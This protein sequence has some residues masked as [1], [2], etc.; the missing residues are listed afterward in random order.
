MTPEELIARS[1]PRFMN[2][3]ERDLL[4][5]LKAVMAERDA[6]IAEAPR[7]A[8]IWADYLEATT[9]TG[10]TENGAI[11]LYDIES[12]DEAARQLYDHARDAEAQA[13]ALRARVAE[14]EVALQI[15]ADDRGKCRTCGVLAVGEGMGVTACDCVRPTWQENDPQEVARAAL[16]AK[17]KGA[18]DGQP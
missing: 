14:L 15:I 13:A 11:D 8:E 5:A 17:A 12:M 16:R 7:A 6:L 1:D 9:P 18:D 4:A 2:E 10:S 3:R